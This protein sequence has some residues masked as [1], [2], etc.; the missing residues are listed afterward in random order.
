MTRLKKFFY[1]GVCTKVSLK[2]IMID[3]P[4][5]NISSMHMI[6]ANSNLPEFSRTKI[7]FNFL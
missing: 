6:L 4:F 3:F 1:F 7:F 2:K 5:T